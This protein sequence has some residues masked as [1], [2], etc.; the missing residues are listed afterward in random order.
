MSTKA[1]WTIRDREYRA[2]TSTL[3]Q[4]L[5]YAEFSETFKAFLY[6]Q[7]LYG[8]LGTGS[9]GRPPRLSHSS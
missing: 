3:T 5:N 2:A 1:V 4:L 6:P 9:T 7:R 8:L